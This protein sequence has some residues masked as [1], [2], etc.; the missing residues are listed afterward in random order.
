M[1]L[2]FKL[3]Q[4]MV[5]PLLVFAAAFSLAQAV[6]GL[7]REVGSRRAVNQRL[8]LAQ[9]MAPVGERIIE[10]RKR[11]GLTAG[12]ER[13]LS[14]PWLHDLI[15]HSGTTFAPGRWA[16]GALA[17]GVCTALPVLMVSKQPLWAA[18]AGV[19]MLPLAP[20]LYL[21]FKAG[22]RNKRLGAQLP[23][24][25]EVVVRSLEAGHPVPTAISLVGQEMADPIGSEFGMVADE[26]A[27]GAAL[28]QAI[29]RMA[30][31]CRNVDVDLFA[32]TIRLQERSGG[33]LTGLLKMNAYTIRE[34][35]KMRL[36]IRAATSEGR[37]SA[38]ILT[39]APFGVV[40][41]LQVMSPH[42]YGDVINERPVQ[43]SLAV[44]GGWMMLGNL[45]MRRMIAMKI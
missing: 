37:A 28:G 5:F 23:N 15:M 34:R 27:Y 32:A 9:T 7:L 45:V 8:R 4:Q 39:A 22:R 3:D 10:L 33:G 21:K 1:T 20:I 41:L 29:G 25:L 35:Q 6:S 42:F 11:R 12:G 16:M 14:W 30:D 19:L 13:R 40:L 36:K 24:A 38:M 31:R 18:A 44:L 2:P 17:A 43:I 26:I